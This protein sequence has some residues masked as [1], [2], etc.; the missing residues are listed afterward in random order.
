[1]AS[2]RAPRGAPLPGPQRGRSPRWPASLHGALRGGGVVG[3][4]CQRQQHHL[5]RSVGRLSGAG[6]M[7]LHELP[8]LPRDEEG[9]IF[10]AP[11]EA[12]AFGTI[13]AQEKRVG[14]YLI[15]IPA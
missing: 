1:M 7:S 11:W 5:R 8:A 2:P 10:R 15:V 9:P 6:L 4:E 13:A 14:I 3:R 12:H